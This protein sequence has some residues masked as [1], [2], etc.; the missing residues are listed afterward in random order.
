M[1]VMILVERDRF[2]EALDCLKNSR[3]VS[4]PL[5]NNKDYQIIS[6]D[7]SAEEYT[8]ISLSHGWLYE[9]MKVYPA[10]R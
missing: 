2:Q 8:F 3:I 10:R 6:A 5:N 9:R 7:M 1:L 4:Y